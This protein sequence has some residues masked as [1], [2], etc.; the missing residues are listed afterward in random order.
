MFP[1]ADRLICLSRRSCLRSARLPPIAERSRGYLH[2]YSESITVAL[3]PARPASRLRSYQGQVKVNDEQRLIQDHFSE[4]WRS[5]AYSGPLGE[6]VER[7]GTGNLTLQGRR[8]ILGDAGALHDLDY[9]KAEL[10]L[11]LSFVGRVIDSGIFG[12]D[13]QKAFTLL[14]K[15]FDVQEGEFVRYRPVELA[16]LLG[17]QLDTI[18]EDS[19]IDPSEDVYQVAL[20]DAFDLGYDQYLALC[21]RALEHAWFRLC[22]ALREEREP[23]LVKYRQGRLDDLEPLYQLAQMQRRTLGALY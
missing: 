19:V 4:L 21:R 1:N 18:L 23:N 10:D 3:A 5:G 17:S 2:L 7:L 15:I 8:Q 13:G 12:P 6:L 9:R 14:K 22:E 16:T 20:Q 11:L